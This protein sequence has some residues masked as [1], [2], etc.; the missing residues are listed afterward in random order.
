M[1]FL[2]T[3]TEKKGSVLVMKILILSM[4]LLG[5]MKAQALDVVSLREARI[6]YRN[7]NI[8]SSYNRPL[9]IYP[10]VAKEGIILHVN[11]DI[12]KYGFWDNSVEA[13]TTDAQYRSIGLQFN[14]GLRITPWLDVSYWHH[15]QHVLERVSSPVSP[16]PFEGAL[17]FSIKLYQRGPIAPALLGGK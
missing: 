17:Q 4:M 11:T 5:A 13:L 7:Y 1:I 2:L 15:S 16:Y 9:L 14:L 10:E 3:T 8:I 6:D 12:L